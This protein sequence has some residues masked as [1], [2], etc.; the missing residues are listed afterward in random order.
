[1]GRPKRSNL[2]I[3]LDAEAA[4]NSDE[5]VMFDQIRKRVACRA[6]DEYG[7]SIPRAPRRKAAPK[8]KPAAEVANG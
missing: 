4:L 1:V 7:D 2:D 5:R 6:A 3:A 8:P